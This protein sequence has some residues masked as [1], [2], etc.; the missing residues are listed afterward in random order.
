[1]E[2]VHQET[3]IW[4]Y[5]DISCSNC[6]Y[7]TTTDVSPRINNISDKQCRKELAVI[8]YSISQACSIFFC[9]AGNFGKIWSARGQREIQYIK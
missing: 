9:G 8:L 2:L 3:F 5:D 6:I 4:I 7:R 1:V